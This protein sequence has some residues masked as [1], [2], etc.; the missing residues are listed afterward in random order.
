M[1]TQTA[2]PTS[3]LVAGTWSAS[4]GTDLFAMVDE[5]D[6]SDADYIQ[7]ADGASA[8]AA[9]LALDALD[10]PDAGTHTL[11]VRAQKNSSGGNA[12]ALTAQLRQGYVDEGTPGTLIA[13]ALDTADLANGWSTTAY[14]LTS[15]EIAT[16]SDYTD[17]AVRLV[18]SD[19]AGDTVQP[20]LLGSTTGSGSGSSY[21]VSLTGLGL[22]EG[23]LVLVYT[24]CSYD[25]TSGPRGVTSPVDFTQIYSG[26]GNDN[27]DANLWVGIKL[28]GSTPNSSITVY[29]PNSAFYAGVT[30]VMA[31]RGVDAT[32]PLDVT[33]TTATGNNGS[34][35]NPPAITPSTAGALIVAGGIGTGGTSQTTMT[36]PSP[37]TDGVS[38]KG[39]GSAY[40]AVASAAIYADWTSGAF[41]P[42]AWTGGTS[43]GSDSW[44]AV[45]IALRPATADVPRRAQVS[46]IQ[47]EVPAAVQGSP[48]SFGGQPISSVYFGS[49]PITSVYFGSTQVW[50]SA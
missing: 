22:Q 24:G 5:A 18:A 31:F 7:S 35:I 39:D 11:R 10:T 46:W 41:D 42:G 48:I 32:T 44:A 28:M 36:A 21:S 30:V 29:G 16:I 27:V 17:L 4:S 33:I 23:D 13:T 15:G 6:A 3:D 14:E 49:D 8:N 38:V 47:L 25:T 1:A 12:V 2:A 26:S 45:T 37:M 43:T 19:T 34:R 40:D 20:T 50:P 9:A